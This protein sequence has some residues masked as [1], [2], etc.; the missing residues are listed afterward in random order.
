MESVSKNG[1]ST[2]MQND[3]T[4][5]VQSTT[6]LN[7]LKDLFETT[8]NFNN[9]IDFLNERKRIHEDVLC[10]K[11]LVKMSIRKY[12]GTSVGVKFHCNKCKETRSIKT[13]TFF[14]KSK[15]PLKDFITIIYLWAIGVTCFFVETLISNVSSNTIQDWFSICRDIC[16]PYKLHRKIWSQMNIM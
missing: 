12:S 10:S 11:C 1:H 15:V 8:S 5:S 4:V 16:I 14:E 6:P 7:T 3:N 9:L 13:G 2:S